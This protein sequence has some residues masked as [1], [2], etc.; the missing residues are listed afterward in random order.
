MVATSQSKSMSLGVSTRCEQP[1]EHKRNDGFKN[2]SNTQFLSHR[3]RVPLFKS[4]C[5]FG[6]SLGFLNA[7][8][9]VV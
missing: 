8:R 5:V 4:V 3:V 1:V 9:Q 2:G 6:V 7:F